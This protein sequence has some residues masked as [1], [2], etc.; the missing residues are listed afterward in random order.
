MPLLLNVPNF[1][2]VR[3]HSGNRAADTDGCI[4]VGQ[5][6]GDNRID[7]SAKA[8]KAL[9]KKITGAWDRNE[10]ISIEI[11]AEY[12]AGMDDLARAKTSIC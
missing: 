8:Y 1:A 7:R 10:R 2:G 9:F 3:I 4:L 11:R 5:V 6:K 12:P